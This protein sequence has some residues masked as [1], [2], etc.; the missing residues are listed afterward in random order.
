MPGKT[1]G[2]ATS[3]VIAIDGP[4]ASGKSTLA[5]GLASALGILYID[6]GAMY[7][8]LACYFL[9]K[10]ILPEET[11]DF[12]RRVDGL[13]LKYAGA[14]QISCVMEGR[15]IGTVVFP[16]AKVKLFLTASP[17]VRAKRRYHELKEKSLSF[18]ELRRDIEK[19]DQ[20]DKNRKISPLKKAPDAEIVDT[21]NLNEKEVL[22][23]IKNRI[24]TLQKEVHGDSR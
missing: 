20:A 10:G 5:K 17:E 14:L 18:E 11:P 13:R 8:G 7:R 3:G 19:R 12:Q 23:L 15:D 4:T 24:L 21:T 6:T 22:E 1:P 2:V 9:E 16:D